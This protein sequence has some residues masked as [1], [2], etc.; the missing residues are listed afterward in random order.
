MFISDRGDVGAWREGARLC[1]LCGE[2]ATGGLERLN[3]LERPLA[4]QLGTVKGKRGTSRSGLRVPCAHCTIIAAAA[5]ARPPKLRTLD[6]LHSPFC[7]LRGPRTDQL[8]PRPSIHN[9]CRYYDNELNPETT[10]SPDHIAVAYI[11]QLYDVVSYIPRYLL[12]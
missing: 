10:I 12:C 8:S 9:V 7:H 5:A 6:L 4:G 1:A 3:R 2:S 11:I